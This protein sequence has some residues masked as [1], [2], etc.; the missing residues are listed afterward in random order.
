MSDFATRDMRFT[1]AESVLAQWMESSSGESIEDLCRLHS[2]IALEL[3]ELHLACSSLERPRATG[4]QGAPAAGA[5]PRGF[6]QATCRYA[7][8]TVGESFARGGM[9]EIL[10]VRD[11][12]LRRPRIQSASARPTRSRPAPC[13]AT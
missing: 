6:E 8:Y 10:E 12:V 5:R 4:S 13:T 9:G 1:R 11:E 7:D 3:R 2:E